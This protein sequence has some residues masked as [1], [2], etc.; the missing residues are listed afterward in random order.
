M[1]ENQ[2]RTINRMIYSAFC[3]LLIIFIG[4]LGWNLKTTQEISVSMSSIVSAVQAGKEKDSAH[5]REMIELRTRVTQC[6]KDVIELR[7]RISR[8]P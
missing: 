3:G 1:S 6:E 7:A 4:L 2:S 8:T 5:D